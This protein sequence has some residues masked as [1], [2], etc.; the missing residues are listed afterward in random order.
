MIETIKRDK[1]LSVRVTEQEKTDLLTRC[2]GSE[3]AVWMRETCLAEKP[4]RKP[5]Y[6][7]IDPLLLQQLSGIGNNINQ[8]ARHLNSKKFNPVDKVKVISALQ[9]MA[10]NIES[11]KEQ[12][13]GQ[14]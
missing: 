6:P 5:K 1:K 7:E 13:R 8:I 12:N 2:G 14:Q 3:L 10:E 9:S 11:I 4:K